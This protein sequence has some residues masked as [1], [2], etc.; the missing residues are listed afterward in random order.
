MITTIGSDIDCH[1]TNVLQSNLMHEKLRVLELE[2]LES[3]VGSKMVEKLESQVGLKEVEELKSYILN[4]VVDF[5]HF[6]C[7]PMICQDLRS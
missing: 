6:I 3:K 1:Q 4:L 5:H 7:F 2:E